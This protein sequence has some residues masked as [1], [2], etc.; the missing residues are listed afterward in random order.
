MSQNKQDLK[1]EAQLEFEFV[2]EVLNKQKSIQANNIQIT[3]MCSFF[4]NVI[5]ETYLFDSVSFQKL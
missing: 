1:I 5:L 3:D 2:F 4:L